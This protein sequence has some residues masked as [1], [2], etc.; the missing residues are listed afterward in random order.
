MHLKKSHPLRTP[1][2]PICLI[3]LSPC[4]RR[5]NP[6][7]SSVCQTATTLRPGWRHIEP[8]VASLNVTTASSSATSGETA[9]NLLAVYGAGAVTST[10]SAQRR[11][12]QLPPQHAVT[13]CWWKEKIPTL[14]IIGA[15]GMPRRSFRRRRPKSPPRTQRGGCLLPPP[16]PQVCPSQ[17]GSMAEK[18]TS[19]NLRHVRWQWQLLAQWNRVSDPH[20]S[21][22]SNQ[23]VSQ[24]GLKM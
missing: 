1:Q 7:K 24:F 18:R 13:A 20:P 3:S 21:K 23:Q 19:H 22:D 8:R 10:K 11:G 2:F 16:P 6:W 15:A 12:T 17:W 9:N 5:Q 14:P 4:P